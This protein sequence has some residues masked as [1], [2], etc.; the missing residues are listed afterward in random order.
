MCI[1]DRC[2]F[3][4]G[5]LQLVPAVCLNIL[6]K[7]FEGRGNLSQRAQW[8]IVALLYLA[9]TIGSLCRSRYDT[10]M[11]HFG[12]QMYSAVSLALYEKALRLSPTARAEYDTGKI[13]TLFSVD[14]FSV[15][16]LLLFIGILFSGPVIITLCL[17]LLNNLSLIHI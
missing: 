16:R 15:Q 4:E 11:V 9:P 7:H 14:A 5:V 13:V 17:L 1:R 6:V 12:S 10:C 2:Y 8:T 3:I